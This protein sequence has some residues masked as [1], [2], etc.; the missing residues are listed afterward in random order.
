MSFS[1]YVLAQSATVTVAAGSVSPGNLI[2]LGN[3]YAV[4]TES[5]GSPG[6][7]NPLPLE[8]LMSGVV[9]GNTLSAANAYSSAMFYTI[10]YAIITEAEWNTVLE[11]PYLSYTEPN[12]GFA[13]GT[14]ILHG[15]NL[16]RELVGEL[17]TPAAG[18]T[19]PETRGRD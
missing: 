17:F 18:A 10:T 11:A 6:G 5:N 14:I 13:G 19:R 1:R 9:N 2:D 4:E 12:T 16:T 7:A 8:T 15:I 3:L